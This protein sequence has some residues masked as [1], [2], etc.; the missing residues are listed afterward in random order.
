MMIDSPAQ[1]ARRRVRVRD[2]HRGLSGV[3]AALAAALW[4][5]T[6]FAQ[7]NAVD[8]TESERA[9]AGGG[10]AGS[11]V[12]ETETVLFSFA[13]ID[14]D[15]VAREPLDRIVARVREDPSLRVRIAAHTD[16]RGWSLGNIELS[17]LRALAVAR[18]LV[19]RGLTAARI[20]ARAY[21][22]SMPVA[23]NATVEGRQ[24]NRRAEIV[25]LR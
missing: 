2:R 12:E 19:E 1:A 7:G 20:S 5:P 8:I 23:R 3:A 4:L 25:L 22:E 15:A 6:A 24:K 16:N 10:V 11:T 13:G 14:L 9:A 18:A 21:G 17:R